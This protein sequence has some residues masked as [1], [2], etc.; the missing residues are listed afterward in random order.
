M[1]AIFAGVLVA[2]RQDSFSFVARVTLAFF[3]EPMKNRANDDKARKIQH[4]CQ[5]RVPSRPVSS[6]F[7]ESMGQPWLTTMCFASVTAVA[8]VGFDVV[9]NSRRIQCREISDGQLKHL[10]R[11][12]EKRSCHV[13]LLVHF[14][15][16]SSCRS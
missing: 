12:D 8:F 11:N 15:E 4:R 10:K 7:I 3:A 13:A 14:D 16:Q 5:R 6:R 2:I 1:E 9:D